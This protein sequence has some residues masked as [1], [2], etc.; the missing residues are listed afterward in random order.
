MSVLKIPQPILDAIVAHARESKPYEC[1]GLL[2]GT[3]GTVSQHYRIKNIVSLEGSERLPSF[4]G[5][6]VTRL[7]Q[8]PLDKRAEI[9]FVMDAQDFSLAKK[10]MRVRGLDLQVVYHS[11]PHSPAV[12]SE[13]DITIAHEYEDLWSKINLAV[14]VYVIISLQHDATPDLRAYRIK[15]RQVTGAEFQPA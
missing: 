1:C 12:P 9:A 5:A 8:L 13:T 10:D 15:N 6:R 11:H 2:A 3:H 7:Q 4:D 14:P